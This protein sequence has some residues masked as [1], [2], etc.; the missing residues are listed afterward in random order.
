MAAFSVPVEATNSVLTGV[1]LRFT[2]AHRFLASILSIGFCLALTF[3]PVA[4][5]AGKFS[6][7]TVDARTGRILFDSDSNGLRYPASLTKMMTLYVVFQELKAKR[8]KLS[9]PLRVSV[10]TSAMPP[11]K[12]GLKPGSTITVEQAIKALVIKSANDVAAT[13]GENLGGSELAFAARM[14]RTARAIG[15]SR[16]TYKNASGLPNPGQVT[17]ARDQATLG[18]HLMRDFPQYYPYFRATRFTFNGRV[19]RTHNRLVERFPGTD[20]IKTG[21]INSSGFNLVTSTRRGDKRLVGVVLGGRSAGSRNSYMMSMLTK[22]FPKAQNGK[23]V[24]ATAGSSKGVVD[25]LKGLKVATPTVAETSQEQDT[26]ALAAVANS[27]AQST[28]EPEDNEVQPP[29]EPKVLQAELSGDMKQEMP[30]PTATQDALPFQVKKPATQADVDSLAVASITQSWAVE[31]GDFKTRKSAA[32]VVAKLKASDKKQQAQKDSKTIM[33]KRNGTTLYRL[34]VSG[35]DEMSAKKSC[36][37]VA[38]LGK[39]C[40]VLSPNG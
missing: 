31:I 9:T 17:T 20:G 24:A 35:Y 27:A 16:T 6:A 39:D 10:R 14:T 2:F 18:L 15:M 13:I 34:M 23:T 28:E 7:V 4:E 21:Y 37:Q 36:A 12:L 32:D 3:A 8:I 29:A 19:I 11:S 1:D 38:K 40:A 30:A 22:A 5:A 33:V 25:P 26:A